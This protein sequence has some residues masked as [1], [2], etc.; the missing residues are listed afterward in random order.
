MQAST[1]TT[2]STTTMDTSTITTLPTLITL[3]E[4]DFSDGSCFSND[5]GI[6]NVTDGSQ[7]GN[8][9]D[10]NSSEPPRGPVS[11]AT[12]VCKFVRLYYDV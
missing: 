12:S 9:I 5:E 6:V 11:D 3:V 10:Q 8:D 2:S 4:C 1:A 7:F